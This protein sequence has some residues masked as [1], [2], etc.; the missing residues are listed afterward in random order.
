[1]DQY[2]HIG[3][4]V[5]ASL[6]ASLGTGIGALAIVLTRQL[7]S[8][9]QGI[10]LGLGGGI[11]LAAAAFS[12]LI[13][14]FEAARSNGYDRSCVIA[15]MI[16][17]TI[18]GGGVLKLVLDYLPQP[19][20]L[21]A[22]V[23]ADWQHMWLLVMAIAIHN[24]PEGLAVGVGFNS[25]DQSAG[26]P[27]VIGVLLQNLPEGLIV[28]LALQQLN[29]STVSAIGLSFLTGLV[30]PIGS[31]VGASI[32]SFSQIIFPWAMAFAAGAMLLVVMIEIIPEVRQLSLPKQGAW[33]MIAGFIGMA[34]L[35]FVLG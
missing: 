9:H 3:I 18:L 10:L 24:F 29:Y 19:Q 22:G 23:D 5:A 21:P 4:S 28:A 27:L 14:G 11:M 13:P 31:F 1:M 8:Q 17:A 20:F 35:D 12:L 2:S 16:T 7:K 32:I 25:G 33:G 26:L 30:E 15:I 34:C 6:I